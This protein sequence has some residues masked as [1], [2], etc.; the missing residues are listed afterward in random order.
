MQ[1]TSDTFDEILA[2]GDYESE[3]KVVI[4][5]VT[6]T[7]DQLL[8]VSI[9]RE[10][11]GGSDLTIGSACVASCSITL[12]SDTMS[13]RE[14]SAT[15]PRGSR[16]EIWERINGW[17]MSTENAAVVGAARVGAAIVGL[18]AE[19]L[20]RNSEWLLQGVFFIDTRDASSWEGRLV[21]DGL[22]RMALADGNY[23]SGDVNWPKSD[24][25]VVNLIA[26]YIGV[27]VDSSITNLINRN[28]QIPLIASY[29]MREVLQY[30]GAMYCGNFIINKVGDLQFLSLT[31]LP[32]ETN[33]LVTQVGNP[34]TFGGVS[35][36]VS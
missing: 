10:V 9:T 25:Q 21:I 36:L 28:Y 32:A 4:N 16:V 7:E 11:F 13:G 19:Y 24:K 5:G 22:D 34:I 15:I 29:T 8:D 26:G 23:P 17:S 33:L 2:S 27:D 3:V 18:A 6:Y 12:I 35:I 14:L 20:P 30:I 31:G 1:Y